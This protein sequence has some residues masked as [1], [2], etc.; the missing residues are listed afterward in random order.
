MTKSEI[1]LN[2]SR[3]LDMDRLLADCPALSREG[4]RGLLKEAAAALGSVEVEAAEARHIVGHAARMLTIRTDGASRGNPGEAGIGVL[5]TDETGRI[6]KK[7]ARY[8]GRATN[9]QAE[10]EALLAGL[11]AAH[12]SGAEGIS[13]LSDSELLVRQINGVYR[14]KNPELKVMHAKAV[15][16]MKG[17]RR[18]SVKYVPREQN[19]HA[20]AF[21]NEAIDKR[22]K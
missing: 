7:I 20:D 14:V 16:I 19:A 15:S 4:L 6:V 8:I 12:E 2:L 3:Y 9:N 5:V 21:A 10:Y 11:E 18:V 22:L 17:F 13:V 1:L